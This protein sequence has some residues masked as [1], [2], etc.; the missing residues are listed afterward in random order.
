[1]PPYCMCCSR[2]S[3]TCG[4]FSSHSLQ[5]LPQA[6]TAYSIA[7]ALYMCWLQFAVPVG[8]VDKTVLGDPAWHPQFHLFW[9]Q[10]A[11]PARNDGLRKWAERAG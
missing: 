7:D 10:R 3:L 2:S 9:S 5:L 6:L 8:V 11:L 4:R 1:M